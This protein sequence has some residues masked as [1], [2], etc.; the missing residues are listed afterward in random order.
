MAVQKPTILI[1]TW[2]LYCS[3]LDF[4]ASIIKFSTLPLKL[5]NT[6]AGNFG[7]YSD[8]DA[9]FCDPRLKLLLGS[10]IF[11]AKQLMLILYN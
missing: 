5:Y 9:V 7:K 11:I 4:I 2:T 6:K 1:W 3:E 8:Y 10:L